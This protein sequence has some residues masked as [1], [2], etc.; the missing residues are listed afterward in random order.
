MLHFLYTTCAYAQGA[1][2]K[3]LLIDLN[4][5]QEN[6]ASIGFQFDR[7]KLNRESCFTHSL[8][9]GRLCTELSTK[10]AT[11]NFQSRE[12]LRRIM[13]TLKR[14]VFPF[15]YRKFSQQRN[16]ALFFHYRRVTSGTRRRGVCCTFLK[17]GRKWHDSWKK[18]PDFGHRWVKFL[19]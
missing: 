4:K 13:E 17:V 5:Y 16:S 1:K 12:L 15:H 7:P 6:T 10:Q 14:S 9:Y 2:W 18:C 11:D 3:K 19:I 8:N